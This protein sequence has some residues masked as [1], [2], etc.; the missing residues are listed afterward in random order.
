[1][2]L[3]PSD[4]HWVTRF[5]FKELLLGHPHIHKIWALEKKQG[6][7]GL[8]KLA[9]ELRRQRYTHVYDAHNNLR[10]WLICAVISWQF[11]RPQ[12]LR[13]SQKRWKRFLLFKLRRN[14]FRQPFSGQRDL[15]EPLVKWGLSE[16]MPPT[17]QLYIQPESAAKALS[18]LGNLT[19]FVALAPSA[20]YPLKR[21]PLNHWKNL[22]LNSKYHFVLLGGPEDLFLEEL[23]L[24]C[25]ERVLNLAGKLSLGESAAIVSRSKCLIAN[26]TGLLHVAEQ[27]GKPCVALMGPAPFGF[28]SRPKTQIMQIDLACRPC[29]KHGQGPCIN[30]VFQ[31]CL[32]EIQPQQVAQVLAKAL[33]G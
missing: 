11:Q 19:D 6:F 26:D 17:P 20:A 22:I 4:L 7:L 10:S 32:V 29:S 16:A 9:L 25:P 31:R 8:W 23:V 21:W 13:K 18:L 15:L 5:D 3:G 24:A 1:M 27:L 30:N 14:Y 28:P 2:D 33:N 12:F